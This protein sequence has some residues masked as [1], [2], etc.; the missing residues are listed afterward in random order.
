MAPI[1][2][3]VQQM[4]LMCCQLSVIGGYE[5]LHEHDDDSVEEDSLEE[6]ESIIHD[7]NE[8]E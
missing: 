7:A 8:E 3:V 4:Q 1:E 2:V 6:E 5:D